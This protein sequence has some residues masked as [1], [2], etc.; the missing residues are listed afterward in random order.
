MRLENAS[1]NPQPAPPD[2]DALATN[3][4]ESLHHEESLRGQRFAWMSHWY[5]YALVL[6][7]LLVVHFVQ[8]SPVGTIGLAMLCVPLALNAYVSRAVKIRQPLPWL[9]YVYTLTD[10]TFLTL[11][12]A[13]DTYFNSALTPVTTATLLIYPIILFMAALRHDR[14]LIILATAYCVLAMNTLFVIAYPYFDPN[15]APKLVCGNIECQVYRTGYIILFGGLLL[16]FPATL[17]RLLGN[18]KKLFEQ[19]LEHYSLAHH[20]TLTGLANR[21]LFLKFLDKILP[22]AKR[23]HHQFAI[24]YLDLDGF[25]AINDTFGHEAGDQVLCEVASRLQ[26]VVRDS[27]LVARFGGDEFVVIAQKVEGRAGA[28]MVSQRILDAIH[29]PMRLHDRQVF[30]GTS[31]G[32][33]LFPDDSDNADRLLQLADEALYLVKRSG[34]DG[35]SFSEATA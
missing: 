34:K 4:Y 26:G 19:S 12:N 29:I 11:Y 16:I 9:P 1:V 33:A 20:D 7:F 22:L 28:E 8:H 30:I 2:F 18:Q 14:K 25:K 15:V 35:S 23:H 21:R 31:I 17:S 32:I 5:L 24:L 13:L 3:I 6:V 27:D 10:L